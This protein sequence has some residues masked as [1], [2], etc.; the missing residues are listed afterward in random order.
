MTP[1]TLRKLIEKHGAV[2]VAVM[3]QIVRTGGKK[4]V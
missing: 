2:S 1:T 3:A 4:N